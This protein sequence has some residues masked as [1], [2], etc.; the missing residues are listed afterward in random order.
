MTTFFSYNI[1]CYC[2]YSNELFRA[3]LQFH[4]ALFFIPYSNASW[5][6]GS[7]QQGAMADNVMHCLG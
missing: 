6:V 3:V 1:A 7:S 5:V 4:P 2:L